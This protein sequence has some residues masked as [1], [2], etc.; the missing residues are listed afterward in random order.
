[1]RNL[2]NQNRW[3][4]VLQSSPVLI[5]L[6]LVVLTFAWS[7]FGFWGKMSDTKRNRQIV[8]AKVAELKKE[9]LRLSAD[10]SK[11]NTEAGVEDSIR[12]KFGLAKEGEGLIVVVEDENEV[13]QDVEDDSN[14]L[15]SFFKKLFK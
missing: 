9:Q 8:E 7:V 11:L 10:I 2:G 6:F 5:I 3:R 4:S 12:E 1:M 15:T 13:G 14:W